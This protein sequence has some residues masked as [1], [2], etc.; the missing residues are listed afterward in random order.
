MVFDS[1]LIEKL[2]EKYKKI[3]PDYL[4]RIL[5]IDQFKGATGEKEE[6]ENLV[7]SVPERIHKRWIRELISDNHSQHMGAWF[8]IM[9][10]G[11]LKSFA[12]VEVEP[13]YDDNSPDFSIEINQQKYFLEARAIV[14]DDQ[15]IKYKAFRHEICSLL[16]K[17]ERGFLVNIEDVTFSAPLNH[18][19]FLKNVVKWLDT[20]PD[21][22]LNYN[23]KLGNQIFLSARKSYLQNC[24]IIDTSVKTQWVDNK[25]LINP[26]RKKA[27]Q[28][29]KVRNSGY[30]YIIAVYLEPW[31]LTHRTVVR[32]WFGNNKV[33]IDKNTLD[34]VDTRLDKSGIHYFGKKIQHTTVSGTLVFESDYDRQ[35]KKNNLMAWYIQNPYAKV[36]IKNNLFPTNSRF[37]V[38]ENNS[39][40]F[41]MGWD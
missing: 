24:I 39:N 15:Y 22:N 9:L 30:P 12:D 29:K 18:N 38:K 14:N 31:Q 23:D 4:P 13:N 33:M 25:P 37:L 21:K 28:H 36:P 3:P 20:E 19:E 41:S 17:I 35:L 5:M 1:P 40:S 10:F 2:R 34:V 11:W 8:E 27:S 26:L 7:Q 16:E 32:T 6:I